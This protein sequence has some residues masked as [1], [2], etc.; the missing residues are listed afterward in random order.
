M[1]RHAL[2]GATEC[3]HDGIS[4]KLQHTASIFNKGVNKDVRTEAVYKPRNDGNDKEEA[5]MRTA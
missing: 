3:G 1:H 5:G 4:M 2:L